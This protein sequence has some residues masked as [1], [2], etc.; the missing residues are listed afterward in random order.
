MKTIICILIICLQVSYGQ[1]QSVASELQKIRERTERTTK[2][3]TK[4]YY[5]LY[6]MDVSETPFEELSGVFARNGEVRYTEV[7][8]LISILTPE[9]TIIRDN[10]SRQILVRPPGQQEQFAYG[11]IPLDKILE[12]C[13]S[14]RLHSKSDTVSSCILGFANKPVEFEKVIIEYNPITYDLYSVQA[15][16]KESFRPAYGDYNEKNA[17]VYE[18][19]YAGYSETSIPAGSNYSKF[20]K[21]TPEGLQLIGDAQDFELIDQTQLKDQ[22]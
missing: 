16:Y 17:E 7:G 1:A 22:Q 20:L 13:D 21:D 18:I 15:H 14:K 19:A 9:L 11:S 8:D 6:D 10:E 4:V 12:I 3:S 5:R 2:F